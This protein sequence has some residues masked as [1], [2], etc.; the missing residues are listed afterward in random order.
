VKPASASAFVV[1]A[2]LAVVL[3]CTESQGAAAVTSTEGSAVEARN[4]SV[5]QAAFAAWR[6]GTGSP[7]DLLAEDV[8]WTIVGHSDASKTYSSREAFMR[9]VIRPFNA[10]MRQGLR[11]TLRA[12]HVDGDTVIIFFDA[13]GTARDGK[14]YANTY[15]PPI[16]KTFPMQLSVA[17][18]Q[19]HFR[20]SAT[21]EPDL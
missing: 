6:D 16:Q 7:Y 18:R 10:R 8:S 2:L 12:L 14:V 3:V 13:S 21:P 1:A 9:E 15:A 5:V 4:R 11:P 19:S 20:C 17:R